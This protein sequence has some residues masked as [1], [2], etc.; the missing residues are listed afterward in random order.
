MLLGGEIMENTSPII[1]VVIPVYMGRNFLEPLCT[2]LEQTLTRC[3][4]DAY[5]I[6]LINDASPDDCWADIVRIA[7]AD[8]RIKGVNL[9][10][11]FG[12]HNA[13]T[14]GL[15]YASG[16]WVV[17]MDCD[18]QD[19][20]EEIEKLYSKAQE[21]YDSVFAQRIKRQDDLIKRLCSKWFYRLF[22]FLTNTRMD[23]SIANFGIYNRKVIKAVLALGDN[24][25]YFPTMVQ[26]VGFRKAFCPVT[27][28]M[29]DMGKS[30][31]SL[32]KL[33][34]LAFESIIAFSEKPLR[35]FV[36]AGLIAAG[37]S[38]LLSIIYLCLA[39]LGH[40][41]VLGYA[42]L[43]LSI[44]FVGGVLM[45]TIGVVGIYVGKIF[46]QVK[47]RPTFIVTQGINIKEFES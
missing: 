13:I 12:Q 45:T 36:V 21:G 46:A 32:R 4:A 25:R 8:E 14:A 15:S 35:I 37:C 19:M 30:S 9:S 11:N 5:E 44:W 34:N 27:H 39:L 7:T 29:R 24:I 31:Y 28:A 16:E 10:R 17:V 18:L 41:K 26:W 47:C 42:S 43:I 22:S 38:F 23:A 33:L 2:R 20:P 40:V 3:V 6:I 1:S